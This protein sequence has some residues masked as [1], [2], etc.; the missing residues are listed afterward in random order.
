MAASVWPRCW[1]QVAARP[2]LGVFQEQDLGVAG[3]DLA[4]RLADEAEPFVEQE[5]AERVGDGLGF[6]ADLASIAVAQ[7][8]LPPARS[9]VEQCFADG[10]AIEPSRHAVG[11]EVRPGGDGRERNLLQDLVDRL[12]FSQS[13]RHDRP[14]PAGMARQG[15]GP[16]DRACGRAIRGWELASGVHH[17]DKLPPARKPFGLARRFLDATR[18]DVRSSAVVRPGWPRAWEGRSR[19]PSR[20]NRG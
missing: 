1:G 19:P 16:V 5:P 4:Q 13:G 6:V 10:Q 14:E 3:R 2:V 9:P 8:V 11:I 20:R 17:N 18:G 12:P 15:R 7:P